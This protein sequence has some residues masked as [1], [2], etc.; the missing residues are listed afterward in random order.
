MEEAKTAELVGM[1][2]IKASFLISR[3][4]INNFFFLSKWLTTFKM[5]LD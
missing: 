5:A 1:S 2:N 4:G 3:G